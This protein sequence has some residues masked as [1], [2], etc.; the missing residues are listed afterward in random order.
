M[1]SLKINAPFN[2]N[3]YGFYFLYNVTGSIIAAVC[4]IEVVVAAIVTG[5]IVHFVTRKVV[6]KK[7]IM[8]QGNHANV[9]ELDTVNADYY[10]SVGLDVSTDD[11]E[12]VELQPS[13]AYQEV[14]EYI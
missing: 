3:D 1:N 9:G 4:Q 2:L 6:M 5:L 8:S 14:T 11:H 13:P 10:E 7:S 12:D